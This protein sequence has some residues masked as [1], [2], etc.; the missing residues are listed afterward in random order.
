[1]IT[2]I[3]SAVPIPAL[4]IKVL[5]FV[6]DLKKENL[7]HLLPNMSVQIIYIF[8]RYDNIN[9]KLILSNKNKIII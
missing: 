9:A 5:T 2:G 4:L 7:I 6:Y 1:M 3:I 8:F